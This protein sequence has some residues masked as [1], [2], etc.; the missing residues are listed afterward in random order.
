MPNGPLILSSPRAFGAQR[1]RAL[2]GLGSAYSSLDREFWIPDQNPTSKIAY[3]GAP[4]TIKVM[5]K[6]ALDDA[7]HFATR[8]LAES[9]CEGL[10]SKD[11]AS[12]Y[13]ALY[14]YLL[15]HSRYMRDPRRVELV[16]APYVLSR[17]MM[18]GHIPS[19]DCD[20]M[21]TWLAAAIMS[22]GGAVDLCTVAFQLM[23]YRGQQQFSHVFVRGL[24]PRTRVYMVLDPVA[25]EKT[26]QMLR[27]VRAA[28]VWPIAA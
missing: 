25:A 8:Q 2:A 4:Q 27:R 9:V 1:G 10:D 21:A 11:Y 16:R 26:P 3:Y 23:M 12:E 5:A 15:Q 20:D 13:L 7:N 22:V 17:Q 19:I 18:E 6:A 28:K 24:E 14:H